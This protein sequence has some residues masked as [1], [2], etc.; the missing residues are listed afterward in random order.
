MNIFSHK[1][2]CHNFFVGAV[3]IS[4]SISF[5]IKASS[6]RV[7]AFAF[8]AK[9]PLCTAKKLNKLVPGVRAVSINFFFSSTFSVFLIRFK[10]VSLLLR[11][12]VS[13]GTLALLPTNSLLSGLWSDFHRL[14]IDHTGRTIG[15]P[16]ARKDI[17][18]RFGA[19]FCI[20][21]KYLL[22]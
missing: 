14:D 11:D 10:T 22:E 15:S 20:E 3:C 13:S 2:R 19:V 8:V 1:I 4:C 7:P 12:V 18:L 5:C 6:R 21:P 9:K 17:Y 16:A